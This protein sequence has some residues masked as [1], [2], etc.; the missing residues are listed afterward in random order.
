[1][2]TALLY[3][4]TCGALLALVH[5]YV[6]KIRWQAGLI[7]VLLPLMFTGRALLSGR[8]YAPIDL[9]YNAEPLSWMKDQYGLGKAHNP[10]LSDV[11]CLNIPWKY[12]VRAAYAN[13]ELPLWNPALYG[14]DILAAAAQP[15]PYEPIFLL[16]L[17]L[18]MANSLT[19]LA[20]ITFFL[21]ALGMYC[22]LREL[23]RGEPESL[24]G[25]AAWMFA[26]FHVF[27]LE[28]VITSTVMWL[29]FVLLSVRRLVRERSVHAAAIL[30]IAFVMMLLNGH[31]ESALH[32]VT[33][34]MIWAAG[35]LWVIR[36]KG[37]VR[38]TLLALAAGAAALL[39]TAVYM[40]PILEAI[41]N[42]GE[43]VM[44]EEFFAKMDK[45]PPFERSLARLEAQ[46]VPFIHGMP[47]AEWP[48]NL[49]FDPPVE[50]AYCG[51]AAI[52][53]AALGAW[54]SKQR[55][56]WVALAFVVFGLVMASDMTPFTDILGALPVFDIAL[57]SRLV[58]A[59]ILG[60]A[61]L[62]SLGAEEAMRGGKATW[63]APLVIAALLGLACANAWDRMQAMRLS[64]SFMRTNA[65]VLIGGA[66]LVAV[67]NLSARGRMACALL[68]ALVVSQRTFESADMYP[69]LPARV[70]YPPIPVFAQL[71]KGG[72]PYR[73][74]GQAGT[75][76]PN[77]ATLY[78]LEDPRGYQ[79]MTLN[80]VKQL[81]PI[82]SEPQ[83]VWFN[84]VDDLTDPFLSMMNVRY[85]VQ[86]WAAPLPAG[87]R[88]IARQPGTHL[89]EN[90]HALGRAFVPHRVHVGERPED[91]LKQI[92]EA[93]DFAEESWI[94]GRASSPRMESNGP[95]RVRVT[96]YGR[97]ALTIRASMDAP[98]WV[99]ISQAAW[100]GWRATVDGQRVP[101]RF[102]NHAFLGVLVP[103]GEHTVRL[104]YLP[105]SFV[106]GA[107]VS[108]A[109]LVLL[110]AALA[111]RM[112]RA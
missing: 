66:V 31:P 14:G 27:W 61:I 4:L 100:G 95:G 36:G 70:F 44:R 39:L 24:V 48:P 15:T 77:T 103:G 20:A 34:G 110:L 52:A 6:V 81:N 37:I 8:V 76:I 78:N 84:R 86:K 7:L 96:H 89:I 79:A 107:W 12:A 101:I 35:E 82:W 106:I 54:R 62:A 58:M 92:A 32:I 56:K 47:Q 5:R 1:M 11:Y 67:I 38:A 50:S 93:R 3:F 16:S 64:E 87:W 111:L 94:D 112:R 19:Y 45:S 99:V 73:I 91:V 60:I 97:G 72:E 13:R 33:L 26:M 109:T 30:T 53:L 42:T 80:R 55:V 74:V 83:G 23:G 43:H 49:P 10:L 104:T 17:L 57:N 85:A 108:G 105:R 98:G 21:L 65:I 71:P 68:L 63:I 51:S 2:L 59:A 22:F 28:W 18:P 90:M 29:P 41:P 9:P 25:A 75:F 69:T 46:A 102:A 40:L 88:L